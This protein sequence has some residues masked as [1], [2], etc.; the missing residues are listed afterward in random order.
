[1]EEI[2]YYTGRWTPDGKFFAKYKGNMLYKGVKYCNLKEPT[3]NRLGFNEEIL[4]NIRESDYEAKLE[5]DENY[6]KSKFEERDGKTMWVKYRK[7]PD[8]DTEGQESNNTDETE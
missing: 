1:M 5:E 4:V 2:I 3:F 6:W 7:V 8:P